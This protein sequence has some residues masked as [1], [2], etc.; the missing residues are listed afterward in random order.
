MSWGDGVPNPFEEER[1]EELADLRAENKKLKEA[2]KLQA[3]AMKT[4]EA[5]IRKHAMDQ[6][7]EFLNEKFAVAKRNYDAVYAVNEK[8]TDELDLLRGRLEDEGLL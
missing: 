5:S 6:A 7:I 1:R 8:L 4:L 2:L 3:A